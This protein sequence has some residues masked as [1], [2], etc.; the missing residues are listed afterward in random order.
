M[1][2]SGTAAA[3]TG[4]GR[5]TTPPAS[6]GASRPTR[7]SKGLKRLRIMATA[8]RF[9]LP[10]RRLHV[11]RKARNAAEG[12]DGRQDG[13]CGEQA[14]AWLDPVEDVED[15]RRGRRRGGRGDRE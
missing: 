14:P 11:D 13:W 1:P 7:A 9:P 3:A 12:R 5:A 6:A 4:P 15:D 2:S 8:S 10:L